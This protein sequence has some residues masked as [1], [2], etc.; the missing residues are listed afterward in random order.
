[1]SETADSGIEEIGTAAVLVWEFLNEN[2]PS[3]FNKVVKGLSM[4]RELVMQAIG[5]LA[6]EDKLVFEPAARGRVLRLK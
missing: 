1:M 3:S 6:R 5:W 2:G 4:T